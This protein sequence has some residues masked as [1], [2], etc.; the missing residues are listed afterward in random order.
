MGDKKRKI[1]RRG[2][3][4]AAGFASLVGVW[5]SA[6]AGLL[7]GQKVRA[8]TYK[9]GPNSLVAGRWAM[10]IDTR[11][12]TEHPECRDCIEACHSWHN[13]PKFPDKK[14]EIKWIWDTHFHNAFPYQYNEY[15]ADYIKEKRI[16]VLCNH[17]ESPP[18]VR[19]CPTQ[20]TFKREDGIVMMD[21]HRCIGCRFCMGACPFG[22]RNFNW[23]DPRPYIK[24]PNY[25]YPTRMR[26][27]VEKC[28]F[29]FDQLHEGKLPI[30]VRACKYGA[31]TFGDLADPNSKV[32]ELLRKHH[33]MRRKVNLGTGPCVFY[34]I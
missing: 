8:Q 5:A 22:A 25:A 13:V 29:C 12:C 17:C 10:V 16:I 27:V 23:F 19:V 21:M 20:A 34:I 9:P 6:T 18:C 30:C 15:D 26:G 14:H 32:N 1:K 24:K 4:K 28:I 7:S 3:L 33:T 31:I 11:I 2:F